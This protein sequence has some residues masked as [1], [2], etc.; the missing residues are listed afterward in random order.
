MGRFVGL[1]D[2][3]WALI[4]KELP[5]KE[6]RRGRPNPDF[7]TVLN[8]ILYVLITGCRW[9]DLPVG[10]QWAKRS[11]A[12]EW[13]GKWSESGVLDRMRKSM[14]NR[15]DLAHLIAWQE[16]AVDGSFSPWEGRWRGRRPRLQGQGS[17][18]PSSH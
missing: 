9:C 11:T 1:S 5:A 13:L 6:A 12:H 15:A 7:R 10:P 18:E 3:E 17:H 8:S 2:A 16:G 14:L 4:G